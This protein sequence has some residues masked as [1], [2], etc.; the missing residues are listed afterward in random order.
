MRAAVVVVVVVVVLA[1]C[2]GSSEPAKRVGAGVSATATKARPDDAIVAQVNGRPIW[3]SCVEAQA[4]KATTGHD[5]R[6]GLDECI[7][8]ELLA[9]EAERRQ[10]QTD[11][12]VVEATR[13]ALVNRFVEIA[14]EDRFE[15]PADMGNILLSQIDRNRAWL[16][17]KERRASAYVRFNLK[18]TAPATEDAK[19]KELMEGFAQKVA[20]EPGLTP[21]HLDALAKAHFGTTPVEVAIVGFFTKNGLAL[22]YRDALFDIPEIGRTA[23]Q[24]VRTQWGWDVI[25]LTDVIPAQKYTREEAAAEAFP[26]VRRG[27]F[28][29]WVDQLAKDS[30]VR[31]TKDEKAFATLEETR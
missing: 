31:I 15:T 16:D 30:G 25:L 19:A 14:Y 24:A 7:A 4:P 3:A 23:P 10:L 12:G 22:G 8:F 11:P 1:A 17:V 20:G 21:S 2:G 27:Y 5:A 13:T 29:V 9:Q 6:A 26:E 18:P 28:N